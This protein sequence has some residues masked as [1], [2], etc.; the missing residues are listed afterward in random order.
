LVCA[1]LLLGACSRVETPKVTPVV[2]KLSLAS[3]TAALPLIQAL[4]SAYTAQHPNVS[5]SLQSGNARAVTEMLFANQADLAAV[6]LLP[7]DTSGRPKPWVADLAMDGVAVIVNPANPVDSIS[8]QDLRDIY[9]GAHNSW[10]DFGVKGLN[11]M[12]VAVREE[13]DGTRATFDNLVMGT[14]N[15]RLTSNAVLLPTVEVAM[16]FVALQANAIAYV[17]TGRITSTVA[18]PVKVL[19][20]DGQL[21]TPAN[22]A[23]AAY[24]LGR[25]LNLIAPSEPQGEL[26]AFVAWALDSDGQHIAHDLNYVPAAQAPH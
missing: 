2:V 21:P 19:G 9:A 17:P 11:D 8:L 6:S 14:G 10:S 3:D 16:N 5:F 7:P 1:L 18:P 26:R 25:M 22:I 13:G 12:Q 15:A 20:I 4:T 24:P 23:S